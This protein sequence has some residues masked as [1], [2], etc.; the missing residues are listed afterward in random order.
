MPASKDIDIDIEYV[1]KLARVELSEDEKSR[2]S[3]QLQDI[4]GY[5]ERI[6]AVDVSDVEPTA[7]A[8]PLFNVWQEDKTESG[9][10]QETALS[11]APEK[12]DNQIRVPKV[13]E[14]A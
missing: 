2:F 4:L 6:I 8:F 1:A 13:V 11:N 7:H 14:D 9:F 12:R 3:Q 5:F 10:T